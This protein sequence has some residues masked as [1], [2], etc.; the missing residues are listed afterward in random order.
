MKMC[1]VL[2]LSS[3]DFLTDALR[4]LLLFLL[5]HKITQNATSVD[6]IYNSLVRAPDGTVRE[7]PLVIPRPV[8]G[9]ISRRVLV[10]DFLHGVYVD[11]LGLPITALPF[12]T[13]FLLPAPPWYCNISYCSPLSRARE[14]M[15]KKGIDPDSP[16]SK[17]FGRQLL[18][19]LTTVFG[20]TILETGFFHAG[21]SVQAQTPMLAAFKVTR[22]SFERFIGRG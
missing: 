1:P 18:K 2:C 9:L 12:L 15:R 21:K 4:L 13:H 17:L 10:Q 7:L 14:E 19:S 6:R 11:V 5:E 16:E 22:H 3:L 8:P 20:R